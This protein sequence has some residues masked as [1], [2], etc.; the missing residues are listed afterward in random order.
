MGG[1]LR[2]YLFA[3]SLSM[4]AAETLGA[5]VTRGVG[6]TKHIDGEGYARIE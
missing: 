6:S 5:T 4:T 1:S 2:V 3:I